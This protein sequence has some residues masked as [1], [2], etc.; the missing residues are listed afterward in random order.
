MTI[1]QL[2]Y[3]V[4]V[5]DYRHFGRAAESCHV[6][7]PTLSMQIQKLEDQLGVVIFDRSKSP[8]EPTE[9]GKRIIEQARITLHEAG[10][11]PEMVQWEKG[12]ISGDVI[13]GIIPTLSPYLLPL[14][15][16]DFLDSNPRVNLHVEELKTEEVLRKLKRGSIDIGLIVT[17]LDEPDFQ[18]RP[19]FYEDFIGYVS[20]RSKLFDKGTLVADDLQ[21]EDLLLL[22][23]GHCFRDQVLNICGAYHQNGNR[24]HYE[25]GSLE[26]LKRMVDKHGGITLLPAL[27]TIDMDANSKAHLRYFSDPV[28]AR[29]ISLV[30]YKSF[31]KLGIAR[32]LYGAVHRSLPE[33][34]NVKK[35]GEVIRWK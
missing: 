25:S 33:Y 22:N 17:P 23:E 34:L 31:L 28:P 26:A 16:N 4:A 19:V 7:Q 30:T 21:V 32:A 24:F 18:V 8:I 3:I 20:H 13:L 12:E 35:H 5:D 1:I 9:A 11:I 2:E 29:E 15:I 10:K 27:A 6:T 14:F